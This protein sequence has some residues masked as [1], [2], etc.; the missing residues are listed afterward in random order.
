MNNTLGG[1]HE[2]RR[3]VRMVEAGKL[4]VMTDGVWRFEDAREAYERVET[5]RARGKIVIAV[6]E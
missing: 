6:G 2:Y 3:V 5:Q 4:R 1:Q